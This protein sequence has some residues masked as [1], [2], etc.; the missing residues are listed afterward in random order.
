MSCDGKGMEGW[1]K[2][3]TPTEESRFNEKEKKNN[4]EKAILKVEGRGGK[5]A[6]GTSEGM[7]NDVTRLNS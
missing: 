6:N 5:S 7:R 4:D 2:K 3:R 1:G